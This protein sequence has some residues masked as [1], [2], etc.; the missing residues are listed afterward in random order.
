MVGYF[1][2]G[3]TVENLSGVGEDMRGWVGILE[4]SGKFTPP[5]SL[6]TI[7]ILPI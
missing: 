7:V 4:S 6:D 3:S 1:W 2:M 5:K